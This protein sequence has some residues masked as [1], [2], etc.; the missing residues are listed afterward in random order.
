ML[1]FENKLYPTKYI[2]KFVLAAYLLL[3]VV[4]ALPFFFKG[5]VSVLDATFEGMS[6]VT[7]TGA[8]CLEGM[9]TWPRE[10]LLW[11]STFTWI[12][13]LMTI[14]LFVFFLPRMMSQ[15]SF[16]FNEEYSGY[17]GSRM[18]SGMS[19]G[20]VFVL[21]NYVVLTVLVY[22]GLL[23]SG[24]SNFESLHYAM[25]VASTSGFRIFDGWGLPNL[26][27]SA[28]VVMSAGMFLAGC[29][30]AWSYF[31]FHNGSKELR[32]NT[33]FKV[34]FSLAVASVVLITLNCFT[35]G[36]E[37]ASGIDILFQ[38]CSFLSTTGYCVS[39]VN[40]WP[41]FA[42]IALP[43]C[44][45]VGGCAGSCAGGLKVCRLVVLLKQANRDIVKLFRPN[46]VEKITIN[47]SHI[48][49]TSLSGVAFFFVAYVLCIFVLAMFLG[50]NGF[51]VTD[52]FATATGCMSNTGVIFS[53]SF[54]GGNFSMLGAGGK[55][56]MMLG[57]LC[58]RLEIFM[59]AVAL[60]PEFWQ[61]RG[62]W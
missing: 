48:Q 5:G 21:C 30:Y 40:V 27:N 11:R 15:S 2:L 59:V 26:N 32:D 12:S 29:N 49:E 4:G 43:F 57:M 54:V 62:N 61:N 10:L 42:H 50:A 55:I 28:K 44:I 31:L 37:G 58:G 34:Y 24:I 1:F 47:G 33:E 17:N 16:I 9:N 20:L 38:C 35:V 46:I 18:L 22:F 13:G 25:G 36:Y 41:V 3:A 56:A 14:L 6:M 19:D 60:L 7:L 53:S 8:T 52:A 39:N 51:N 45:F 23:S